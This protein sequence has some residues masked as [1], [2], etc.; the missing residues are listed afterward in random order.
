MVREAGRDATIIKRDIANAFR[1]IPVAPREQWLLGLQ[2]KG[3]F[4][5]EACLPFGLATAPFI[6]NLFAEAFHWILTSWLPYLH[7]L[8][9]Y[10]DNF[11][12][13]WSARE[14]AI[15]LRSSTTTFCLRTSSAS[16]VKRAKTVRKYSHSFWLRNRHMYIHSSTA[17]RQTSTRNTSN[18][19]DTSITVYNA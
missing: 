5:K 2:W 15:R 13:V 19:S 17:A 1:N 12:T 14:V 8:A 6:F 4:Y 7:R 18:S 9:H 16:L 3:K 11:I 10:L